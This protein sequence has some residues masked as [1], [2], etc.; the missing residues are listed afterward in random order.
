MRNP[1]LDV[2]CVQ[3][4]PRSV[5]CS[6]RIDEC[7]VV[8]KRR[9]SDL[10]VVVRNALW[11]ATVSGNP[12]HVQFVWQ[13]AADKINVMAVRGPDLVMAVYTG[14][15]NIDLFRLPGI[16][17][18]N[19]RRISGL[20][21]VIHDL[22]TVCGP[23]RMDRPNQ[24]RPWLCTAYRRCEPDTE[25]VLFGRRRLAQTEPNMRPIGGESDGARIG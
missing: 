25:G 3:P 13:K 24:K 10:R 8:E 15:V 16:A 9:V 4:K 22:L 23:G 21:F 7:A 20:E 1:L 18:H 19:E 12:P 2:H 11:F 17:V 6:G 5:F 14:L